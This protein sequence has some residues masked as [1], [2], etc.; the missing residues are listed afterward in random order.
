MC[1]PFTETIGR[2]CLLFQ[3]THILTW[4][5]Y[6]GVHLGL[7]LLH[8]WCKSDVEVPWAAPLSCHCSACLKE[9]VCGQLRK[10]RFMEKIFPG[11]NDPPHPT[12]GRGFLPNCGKLGYFSFFFPSSS[13]FVRKISHT[14]LDFNFPWKTKFIITN[15][16]TPTLGRMLCIIKKS[17]LL[18]F[19]FPPNVEVFCTVENHFHFFTLFSYKDLVAQLCPK[20][21]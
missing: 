1:S 8:Q 13:F 7:C 5:P 3:R 9:H 4:K 6:F 16:L 18:F 11:M 21:L 14:K 10:T 2:C 12:L 19:F 17:R 15:P 20:N